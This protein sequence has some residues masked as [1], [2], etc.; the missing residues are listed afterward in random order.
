[1]AKG[2]ALIEFSV[3]D[4]KFVIAAERPLE[5]YFEPIPIRDWLKAVAVAVAVLV[6]AVGFWATVV[7]VALPVV[8]WAVNLF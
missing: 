4:G 2:P 6:A 1:M 5:F 3:A 7:W 8:R